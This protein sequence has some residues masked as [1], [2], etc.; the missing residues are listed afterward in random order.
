MKDLTAY[1]LAMFRAVYLDLVPNVT[2]S[3]FIRS[4]KRLIARRRP[5][6]NYPD[7]AKTFKTGAKMFQ[8]INKDKK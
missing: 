3:K 2:T 7:N 1:I 5:N 6:I 4:L 8:K